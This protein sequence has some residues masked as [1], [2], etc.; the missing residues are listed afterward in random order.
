MDGLS[1][2]VP[3]AYC[4]LRA[5]LKGPDAIVATAAAHMFEAHSRSGFC[6]ESCK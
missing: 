5:R 6:P 4:M 2:V 3:V 1:F